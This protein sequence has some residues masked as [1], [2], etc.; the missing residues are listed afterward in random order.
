[1]FRFDD[2]SVRID[3]PGHVIVPSPH[4]WGDTQWM[5]NLEIARWASL[6]IGSDI[7]LCADMVG[8]PVINIQE[9]PGLEEAA[10]AAILA[11]LR[12]YLAPLAIESMEK[13]D[14][15]SL[16]RYNAIEGELHA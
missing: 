13:I 12:R 2:D 4:G 10:A 8:G 11:E 6:E 5:A 9:H 16:V 14:L 3:L 1:M 7:R 15:W